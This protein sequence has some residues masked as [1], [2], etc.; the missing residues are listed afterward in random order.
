MRITNVISLDKEMVLG[1]VG[2]EDLPAQHGNQLA[3]R[4]VKDT[5]HNGVC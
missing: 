4:D 3:C 1:C 5:V 2:F